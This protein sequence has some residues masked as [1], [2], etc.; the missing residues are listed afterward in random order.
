MVAIGGLPSSQ[1]EERRFI[2]TVMV[3]GSAQ[4][5]YAAASALREGLVKGKIISRGLLPF[6]VI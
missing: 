6:L 2:E 1:R 4:G 5:D 3:K